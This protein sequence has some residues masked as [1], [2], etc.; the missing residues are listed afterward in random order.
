[1]KGKEEELAQIYL[2]EFLVK[3]SPANDTNTSAIINAG[4]TE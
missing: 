4:F 3:Q 1:M 2:D